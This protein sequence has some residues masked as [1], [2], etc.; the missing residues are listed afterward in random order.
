MTQSFIRRSILFCLILF[1]QISASA[2]DFEV[3]ITCV[4]KEGEGKNHS[5]GLALKS[6]EAAEAVVAS[7]DN[8][9]WSYKILAK[10]QEV[11]VLNQS[12]LV[13]DYEIEKSENG[14]KLKR[15]K[16]PREIF[17][18]KKSFQIQIKGKNPLFINC[19]DSEASE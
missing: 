13:I 10:S 14:K 7:L 11:I 5:F 9:K 1:F 2:L 17:A 8:L 4:L 18:R 12:R 15:W 16:L 19:N 3:T 6:G